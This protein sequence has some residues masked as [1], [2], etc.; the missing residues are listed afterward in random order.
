[1]VVDAD[2]SCDLPHAIFV[3]PDVN[4]LCLPDDAMILLPRVKESVNSDFNGTLL[5]DKLR[6]LRAPTPVSPF[7]ANYSLLAER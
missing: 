5:R 2:H 3:A 1:M 4:E 6:A 7:R